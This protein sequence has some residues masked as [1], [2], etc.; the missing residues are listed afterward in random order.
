[1]GIETVWN[2]KVRGRRGRAARVVALM[3][4]LAG[5]AAAGE[6]LLVSATPTG[7]SGDLESGGVFGKQSISR[8]GRYVAFES[9]ASDLGPEDSNNDWDI[10]VWDR[11]KESRVRASLPFDGDPASGAGLNASLSANGRYVAFQSS[12]TV[13]V[14][15]GEV[16][17]D[18]DIFLHDLKTGVTTWVSVD[19]AGSELTG[20]SHN[21]FVSA[22][23]RWI[24]F[25]ST[26]AFDPADDNGTVDIYLHDRKKGAT[27]LVSADS[28]GAPVQGD[29]IG[30]SV[31]ANGRYVVFESS[32]SDLVA[33]DGNGLTDVFLRDVKLGI[34]TR[35]SVNAAG[36]EGDGTSQSA[37]ISGN[38]RFVAFSSRATNLVEDDGTSIADV[39]VRDLK[40]G[41]IERVSLDAQGD[42][43]DNDCSWPWIT[44]NGRFVAFESVA[45][46]L[47]T[48]FDGN[49]DWDIYLH[50]RKADSTLRAS[51]TT[52]GGAVQGSSYGA[53]VSFNGQ[54]VAF[55]SDAADL[56]PGDDN[57]A[58]DIFVRDTK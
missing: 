1:M 13:M 45:T 18:S 15:G 29:S 20:Q 24:V 44:H 6:T 9:R 14:D 11:K 31:S 2:G 38:G 39:F 57:D 25:Q 26:A 23:G 50:D 16:D 53:V 56:A 41:T 58:R 33:D 19:S 35:L 4:A 43:A 42:D 22:N 47:S 5:S 32:A 34:T 46:D 17:F 54:F 8:S 27:L 51:V 40:L 7:S 49:G 21:P 30:A 37:M 10:Y 36:E 52:E 28:N 12:T 3:L 55:E 48:E